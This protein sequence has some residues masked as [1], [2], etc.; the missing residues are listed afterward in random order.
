MTIFWQKINRLTLRLCRQV[1]FFP[2]SWRGVVGKIWDPQESFPPN[3]GGPR[4]CKP[5][6]TD[7]TN[8]TIFWLE[9]GRLTLG[10]Y[11]QVNFFSRFMEQACGQNLGPIGTIPTKFWGS[12]GGGTTPG[13]KTEMIIFWLKLNRLTLGFCRRVNFFSCVMG[14]ELVGKILDP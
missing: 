1:N 7:G 8:M 2:V 13:I 11:R 9:L 6:P 10:F 4:G 5:T 14:G 3:F 12:W